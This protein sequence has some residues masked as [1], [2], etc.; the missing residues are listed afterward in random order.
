MHQEMFPIVFHVCL[1]QPD[2]S[3]VEVSV[4]ADLSPS[5][6][7]PVIFPIRKTRT[8]WNVQR[9]QCAITVNHHRDPE[10]VQVP[11]STTGPGRI[12]FV[13]KSGPRVDDI[14]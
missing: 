8:N 2:R 11:S 5:Q 9:F 3:D 10:H 1:K 13:P 7:D 14:L 6:R 4:V 12:V